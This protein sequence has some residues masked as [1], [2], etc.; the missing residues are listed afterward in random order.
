MLC[1]VTV[2]HTVNS[3]YNEVLV[4]R[5]TSRYNR[6]GYNG[7]SLY[8]GTLYPGGGLPW[9]PG[10]HKIGAFSTVYRTF[11]PDYSSI[12]ESV[13]CYITYMYTCPIDY[14]V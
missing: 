7:G 9:D 13:S 8:Y 12:M 14:S 2:R 11:S 6:L 5:F 1:Q 4:T 3:R 10:T